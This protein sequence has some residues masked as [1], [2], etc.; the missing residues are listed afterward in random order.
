MPNRNKSYIQTDI[1]SYTKN[2]TLNH[3]INKVYKEKNDTFYREKSYYKKGDINNLISV[4][5]QDT[6]DTLMALESDKM[7][8]KPKCENIEIG[9][10]SFSK[11]EL[12]SCAE[13]SS[14]LNTVSK[15]TRPYY[16]RAIEHFCNFC[17]QRIIKRRIMVDTCGKRY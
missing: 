8:I 12:L 9:Y 2:N 13:V 15:S 1:N 5:H 11:K 4:N 14:W 3:P 16:L 10:K 6:C 17:G 7:T